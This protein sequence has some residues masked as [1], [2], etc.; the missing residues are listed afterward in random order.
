LPTY[1]PWAVLCTI[2][3]FPIGGIVAIVYGVLVNRRAASGDWEGAS[4]ASRLARRWCLIS[5]GVA[6]IVLIALASGVVKNPYA[7]N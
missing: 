3:L 1:L 5:V 7:T 6:L 4:R 2:L